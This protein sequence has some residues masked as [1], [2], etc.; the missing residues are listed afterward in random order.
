ME[1]KQAKSGSP[2]T[3]HSASVAFSE[4]RDASVSV[5]LINAFEK[6]P[7]EN[8]RDQRYTFLYEILKARAK[9]DWLSSDFH[10]WSHSRR[11]QDTLPM[12]DRT[13]IQLTPTLSYTRNISIRRFLSY[14]GLS[15]ATLWSL[16]RRR[17]R[18]DVIVCMGPV[19]QMFLVVLYG[20]ARGVRVIIDVIDPWPDVYLQAFPV[21]ARWI[22]RA[23]LAPY[24]LMSY[25]TFALCD[26]V[27]AVSDT[28]LS[29]AFRRGRRTDRESFRRYYLGAR[30]DGFNARLVPESTNTIS[31]LFAG[32]FGFSYDVE[33]I[34]SAAEA[35]QAAGRTD[36]CF[37]L[38]GAGDKHEEV[39]RRAKALVNVELHGWLTT[40]EL[41]VIGSR[42]QVGLCCY[43]S[44]AT[45]SIPT[46]LFD[47]FSMGL[48]V[49]SSL[50][51]E[52]EQLLSNHAI[53]VTYRSGDVDDF[54]RCL[55]KVKNEA[56]IDSARRLAIRKAFDEHFD[57]VV[58]YEKMVQEFVLP[59]G[60]NSPVPVGA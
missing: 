29:W 20:R 50:S 41:N 46:K 8:F 35:L 22:G 45:Q 15:W 31:C 47:Y 13:H 38:C 60:L 21:N 52:A 30:N 57:S 18:P 5:L 40:E 54:I 14:I 56:H 1:T 7:G 49:V 24:F 51:G 36:I 59:L 33:L 55:H 4:P 3:D 19:E 23:L 39:A 17:T 27:A 42:C 6:I 9:V 44:S 28:Y 25:V 34:L 53:G 43:R 48:Y 10:H 32:Q 12:E 16:L 26:S 58:I 11:S 2:V 37:V